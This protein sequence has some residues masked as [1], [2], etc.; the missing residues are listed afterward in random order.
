MAGTLNVN[1]LIPDPGQNLYI[2]T[3]EYGANLIV[4]NATTQL[5][6]VSPSGT[7]SSGNASALGVPTGTTAQRPVNPQIGFIRFN[8]DTQLLEN[9]TANGWFK[10]SVN[11]PTISSISGTIYSGNTSTLTINGTN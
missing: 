8:T 2:N 9:Y 4:G 5:L 1:Q 3:G 10:V 11:V 7:I 6:V